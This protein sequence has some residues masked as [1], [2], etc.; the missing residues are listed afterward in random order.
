M[1]S[2]G[3]RN[4]VPAT[5]SVV[6]LVNEHADDLVEQLAARVAAAESAYRP[7]VLLSA[8]EVSRMCREALA[9][10]TAFMTEDTGSALSRAH[11]GALQRAER[12]VPVTAALHAFR[13][14]GQFVWAA[15]VSD[16]AIRQDLL[17]DASQRVWAVVDALSG[18][19]TD[20]Y[21]DLDQ[22]S[23]QARLAALDRLFH[24]EFGDQ[25]TI[26]E[27]A[28]Q[29]GLP[30]EGR[31]V[32]LACDAAPG[33][34]RVEDRLR[35][36]GV[37][38]VRHREHI[39]SNLLVL[40]GQRFGLDDLCEELTARASGRTGVSEVFT[41]LTAVRA[42]LS[43]AS[44]ARVAA[45]P[46]SATVVRHD[47]DHVPLL[48]ASAPAAARRLA[49]AVLGPVLTLSDR[50]RDALLGTLEAWLSQNGSP[51]SAARRLHCHRNTVGYR[52]RRITEL[53]G[54]D[55]A[56]PADVAQLR[57]ALDVL[58]VLPMS[59]ATDARSSAVASQ[60]E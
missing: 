51:A 34:P 57:L 25:Y 58:D 41:D 48:I 8:D 20:A 5:E 37:Q 4:A 46:G 50:E 3:D 23:D 24:G 32:V 56:R 10:A 21:R 28:V 45:R 39:T 49:T 12:G 13:I 42:A 54:R 60:K 27:C 1:Y 26:Q 44:L 53:T 35:T 36:L 6:R 29:L 43:E 19:V 55:L 17:E 18:A 16:F 40:L 7:G 47:R 22:H 52:L 59:G 30:F 9:N 31:F 38:F 11:D 2:R 15:L 33:P 14:G